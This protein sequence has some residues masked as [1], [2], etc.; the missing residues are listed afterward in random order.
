ME[1]L[2][3]LAVM[4]LI[5]ERNRAR[6]TRVGQLIEAAKD[7]GDAAALALLAQEAAAWAGGRTGV[8]A[9]MVVPVPSSPDR[10][11]LLVPAVAAAIA[12]EFGISLV[13]AL[14]RRQST[15]RLRDLEPAQRP[16]VAAAADYRVVTPVEGE[17]VLLIDDVV[18]TG[19]T[20]EHL[21]AL[22]RAHGAER[23]QASVLAR[24][25]RA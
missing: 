20:L 1:A 15:P 24:S 4:A 7:D 2:D 14:E 5:W 23:V 19:T 6:R 21:A 8:E 18:L 12:A 11:N 9:T 16:A 25:R 17:R 22:L 10:P 13:A 3:H